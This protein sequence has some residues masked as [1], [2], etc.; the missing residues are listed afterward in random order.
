MQSASAQIRRLVDEHYIQDTRRRR[1]TRRRGAGGCRSH[2]FR[3]RRLPRTLVQRGRAGAQLRAR[4]VQR[5][6]LLGGGSVGSLAGLRGRGLQRA[7]RGVATGRISVAFRDGPQQRDIVSAS[8]RRTPGVR[9]RKRARRSGL[10]RFANAPTI[11][12]AATNAC[13]KRRS[14]PCERWSDRRS[15]A[16][17]SSGNTWSRPTA[18]V[19]PTFLAR[20][21]AA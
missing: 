17:G 2:I 6:R 8:G 20:S 18:A 9:P 21:S 11:V 7:L 12:A 1:R 10:R 5:S 19:M 15:N 3:A 4:G 13:S 16:A 14:R